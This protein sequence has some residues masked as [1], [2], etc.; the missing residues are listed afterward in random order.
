M[1]RT[2]LKTGGQQMAETSAG[3]GREET[4]NEDEERTGWRT[5]GGYRI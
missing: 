4:E 5:V 1:V 3:V 2:R